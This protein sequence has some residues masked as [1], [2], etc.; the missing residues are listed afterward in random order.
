MRQFLRSAVL[1]CAAGGVLFA[2]FHLPSGAVNPGAKPD[3]PPKAKP[4]TAPS[5]SAAPTA[6]ATPE[7][8]RF[9]YYELSLSWRGGRVLVEGFRPQSNQG[10]GPESCES[11]RPAPKRV[12]GIVQS[13]M[14]N[15]TAIQNEWMKHGACTGLSAIE[16]FNTLRFAR[17]QVQ[18][19]V[20]LTS[21][22][23]IDSLE[24]TQ[25]ETPAIVESQF[26]GAN[27][28]FPAGAFRASAT[29][30]Q[31]CFDTQLRPRSCSGSK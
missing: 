14:Q 18:I 15:E 3:A 28:G 24:A 1:V 27:A 11:V 10:P 26:V 31:V 2:Q 22:G 29:E 9:D 8:G 4:T 21:L 23:S 16:Y 25:P 30:V 7:P 5:P 13:L 19:P 12:L 17:S 20:Q 6:A